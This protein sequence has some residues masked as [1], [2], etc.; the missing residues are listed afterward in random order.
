[1]C[2]WIFGWE[3]DSGTEAEPTCKTCGARKVFSYKC[4]TLVP[5]GP[6][7]LLQHTFIC[8]SI[9]FMTT[10]SPQRLDVGQKE[11]PLWQQKQNQDG[12]A[13]PEILRNQSQISE[14]ID[15]CHVFTQK[16][17]EWTDVAWHFIA[18]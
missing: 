1:M 6:A 11:I 14:A 9:F 18:T 12:E 8:I 2:V 10:L 4:T 17:I 3:R 13:A 15:Y 5:K 7:G 16:H